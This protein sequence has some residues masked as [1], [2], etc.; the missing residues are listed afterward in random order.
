MKV[1]IKI[2]VSKLGFRL[3]YT[4]FDENPEDDQKRPLP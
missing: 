1:L 3:A 4:Y 2:L